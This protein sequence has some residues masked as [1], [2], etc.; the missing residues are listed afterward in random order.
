MVFPVNRKLLGKGGG[1]LGQL[2]IANWCSKLNGKL[3]LAQT[4]VLDVIFNVVEYDHGMLFMNLRAQA[5]A[6]ISS[7]F[8]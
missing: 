7:R 4:M 5:R 8:S 3:L 1:V 6:L 2:P